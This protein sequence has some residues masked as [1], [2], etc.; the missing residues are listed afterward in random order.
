MALNREI[1][2]VIGHIPGIPEPASWAELGH[3]AGL[4]IVVELHEQNRHAYVV[5]L[6]ENAVDVRVDL[7]R[8]GWELLR[9]Y[10]GEV[11]ERMDR[12]E[13]AEAEGA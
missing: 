12:A 9:Q 8:R 2:T 7:D 6:D 3:T 1:L 4:S 13:L 10:A 5:G 11:L